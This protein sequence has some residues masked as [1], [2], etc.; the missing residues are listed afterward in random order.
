MN[1]VIDAI[2]SR[3]TIK[4]MEIDKAPADDQIMTIIEAATWAPNHH[5]TEPWRFVIV[6]GEGRRKLGD[7]LAQGL[8][9]SGARPTP[10]RIEQ[11]RGKPMSAPVIVV[12]ISCPKRGENIVPQEEMVAAGAALQNMLLAA[13]SLDLG[14]MVRTGASS[15]SAE[16]RDA[17]GLK[18]SETLV[19]M[20]YLG[21]PS[22][23]LPL[24][25][26][27]APQERIT[28]LES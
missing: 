25:K 17:L 3:R 4:K 15:Y 16:V 10:E 26:R 14:S 27:G 12:L 6:T 8:S 28:R 23:P 5:L 7:A 22:G 9:S 21:H 11:E 18:E 2:R 13:H 24:G 20:V 19:G 1:Q